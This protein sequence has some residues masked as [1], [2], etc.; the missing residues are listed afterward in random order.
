VSEVR[1]ARPESTSGGSDAAEPLL[2][3]SALDQIRALS[4]PSS[5]NLLE[6]VIA[7]YL[8]TS[9]PLAEELRNAWQREDAA[10]VAATAHRLKSSSA[11][12]GVVRVARICGELERA[13]RGAE[14][15]MAALEPMVARLEAEL[16]LAR[17]PLQACAAG[18][19]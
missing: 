8:E 14:V 11:Q 19:Q 18:K 15:E 16:A 9:M 12:L 1:S 10:A 3:R 7:T 17:E 6:R 5:S 4:G 2:D 13:A